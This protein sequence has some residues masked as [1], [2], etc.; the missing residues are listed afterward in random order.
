MFRVFIL[1]LVAQAS[2]PAFSWMRGHRQGRLCHC[3]KTITWLILAPFPKREPL[4]RCSC[5]D[6]GGNEMAICHRF[7]VWHKERPV[8][9]SRYTR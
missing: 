6:M 2:L 1:D 4:G 9:C 8:L 7:G 3:P 5:G